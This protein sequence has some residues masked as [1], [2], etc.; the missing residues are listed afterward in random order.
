ME[1]KTL[2]TEFVEIHPRNSYLSPKELIAHR[3]KEFEV[4]SGGLKRTQN[5]GTASELEEL[6]R[7]QDHLRA[8]LSVPRIERLGGRALATWNEEQQVAEVLRKDGKF[9]NFGHSEQGKLYLEY[10][11]AL[12]LLELGRLQL[13]YYGLVVSIEQ[14]YVLLLGELE[15]EKYTNYLV[16]SALSRAGYIVVRHKPPEATPESVTK[17]DCI[18]ALLKKIVGN[19]L[20]PDRIKASPFYAV[21]DKQMEDNKELIISQK[22]KEPE[23]T[24]ESINLQFDSKK[25]KANDEPIEEPESKKEKLSTSG[26][27][28]VDHLKTEFSYT[29]FEEV[30]EKFDIV[31]LERQDYAT[32]EFTVSSLKITFDLHLHNEGYKKSSPNPPNFNVIIL[33]SQEAFPTHDDISKIQNQYLHTAPLLVVSVSESKQIQAFLYFIS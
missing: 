4:P 27:S 32:N 22:I 3:H 31:Q 9:E 19:H 2:D 12:F 1:M 10:Y 20:V 21:V 28:L 7:A 13:E 15:S 6:K 29:K 11:E 18:W 16:Y 25:R 17:A 5:E 24:E 33:T 30:F 23:D 26:R 8:Q 14:A